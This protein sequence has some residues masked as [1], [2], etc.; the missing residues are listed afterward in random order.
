MIIQLREYS[1]IVLK[2][3]VGILFL[4]FQAYS[5]PMQSTKPLPSS[6]NSSG[7]V[8]DPV[9]VAPKKAPQKVTPKSST[10]PS[11]RSV[12]STRK[13]PD[14]YS[15]NYDPEFDLETLFYLIGG[16]DLGYSRY[17][18]DNATDP[19]EESRG[20]FHGGLRALG[21]FYFEKWIFDVGAGWHYI[22]NSGTNKDNKTA[23][24]TTKGIYLEAS[25]RYRLS[26]KFSIGPVF[27][28]W[29]S[30]DNGLNP[31]ILV[32]PKNT[33]MWIGPQ[34]IYEWMSDGWKYRIGGRW[35]LDLDVANRSVNIFQLFFQIG[36][37][38][39]GS[40]DRE[41]VAREQLKKED[42]ET[43]QPEPIPEATPWP[44]IT[45]EPIPEVTPW[46]TPEP[47]P[48]ATPWP[49]STPFVDKGPKEKFVM[50]LD[51]NNLPFELNSARLPKFH[52]DRLRE[53]GRFLG[54]H[55]EAWRELQ[56]KGHTDSRGS[57]AYNN[58]LSL[59][60]AQT[61]RQHLVEGGAPRNKIKAMGFGKRKPIAHGNTEAA[62]AKNRRVELEFR[63][64]KDVEIIYHGVSGH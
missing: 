14:A 50:S 34:G 8:S 48:E 45:P 61:V 18:A 35:L 46:P 58:Q 31:F 20:G 28:Y 39:T 64:V 22:N 30:S 54:E 33:S 11:S 37:P 9:Y 57:D 55:P 38:L 40:Q 47:T 21:G 49:D 4:T 23:K 41:P 7:S 15:S 24:V 52:I 5:A 42:L 62:Y 36:F 63:G 12:K 29:L 44:E 60:R 32:T 3:S 27:D 26:Q 1:R 25:P 19:L 17:G 2:M 59:A 51:V 56:V 53:I 10:R 43:V 16:I 13:N 6:N